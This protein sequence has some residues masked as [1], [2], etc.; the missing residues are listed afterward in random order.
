[1]LRVE[2]VEP[3]SS[4]YSSSVKSSSDFIVQSLQ[5]GLFFGLEFLEDFLKSE[6]SPS[7]ILPYFQ[8]GDCIFKDQKVLRIH[9]KDP[10]VQKE[11]LLSMI[12]Y[13][14]GVYTLVSC[15]TE[16]NFDFSIMANSTPGFD[17][18]DWE[19][20]AILKA[21][22]FISPLPQK[23]LISPE[24]VQ[25]FLDTP[26]NSLILSDS[27]MSHEEIEGILKSL[28]SFIKVSLQ[29]SFF[30]EDLEKFR[31]YHLDSVYPSSL[32]GHFPCL[33]MKLKNLS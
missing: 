7:Q 16:R 1:M 9:L 10:K 21:G 25:P 29:G 23:V 32:Q 6:N 27:E 18:S 19:E 28:P 31:A 33:E 30:P 11:E 17:F 12:S 15:W 2:L 8:D 13:L 20:K 5:N 26:G 14:S 3:V 24:E 4:P 22:A